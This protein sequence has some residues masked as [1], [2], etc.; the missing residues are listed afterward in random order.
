M[1]NGRYKAEL[2]IE[3]SAPESENIKSI[4]EIER[5]FVDGQMTKNIETILRNEVDELVTVT[6]NPVS[7]KVWRDEDA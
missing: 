3:F 5:Y 6:V 7:A 4:E 2:T 1:I